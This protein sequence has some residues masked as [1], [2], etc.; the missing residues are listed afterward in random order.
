MISLRKLSSSIGPRIKHRAGLIALLPAM[1]LTGCK[2]VVMNPS[3]D[4]AAQQADLILVSTALMLLIIVPVIVLTL[5]FAWKYRQS[6]TAAEY[7]PEWDHSTKLELV[8]WGAPLLI[9]IVLGLVTWVSTHKLDPYRPLE[10][11]DASRPL[12][13]DHKPLEI[14]VVAMDWKWLFIYPEQGIATVNELVTPVDRPVRFKITASTVMNSFFIPA[15]AGQI[16]AMPSM[17]TTLNAVINKPG[18]YEGFSANYSGAGFSHMRFKYYGMNDADFDQ[19]VANT[20]K[21]SKTL[22]RALYTELEKPSVKDPVQKFGTVSKDLFHAIV[23]RCVAEGSVCMDAQMMA[24]SL[25]NGTALKAEELAILINKA[26]CTVTPNGVNASNKPLPIIQS[27]KNDDH[28]D[29]LSN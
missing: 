16:Y 25:R 21:A 10:R 2:T 26:M 17:E 24:D 6:N 11:I 3:G 7:D 29:S 5:F 22:D 8:I 20:R 19:W 23:N 13:A 18:E 4:V 14:Q 1:L 12:A 28:D 15:L 27:S 9:I